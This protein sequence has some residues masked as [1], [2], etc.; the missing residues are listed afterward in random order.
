MADVGKDLG[1]AAF[2]RVKDEADA[3][4]VGRAFETECY[5]FQR[6][7]KGSCENA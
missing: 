1:R 7:A 5:H 6:E 3:K 2:R 4:F